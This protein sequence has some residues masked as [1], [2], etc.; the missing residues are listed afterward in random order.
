MKRILITVALS[1]LLPVIGLVQIATAGALTINSSPPG[2]EAVL[3]GEANVSG[4]T[5]VT[6]NYPLI[7]AYKLTVKK[8]GYENYRTSLVLD[9]SSPLELSIDLRPKTGARAALRSAFFPG[10]GQFYTGQK[11]KAFFLGSVFTGAMLKLFSVDD[12][13]KSDRDEWRRLVTEYDLALDEGASYSELSSK[14][15]AMAAAQRE[16]YDSESDRRVML[17][18]VASIWGLNV[19]DALLFSPSE[20]AT[21]SIKGLSV[22]PSAGADGVSLSISKAF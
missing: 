6:F 17:V 7:G 11:T 15:A 10:W 19:I 13:F 20:R 12:E 14:H 2:A 16:A 4:I 5:P 22:V 21:F 9:P 3:E 18:A 8:F 1:L